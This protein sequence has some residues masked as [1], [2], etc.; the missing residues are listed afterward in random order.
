MLTKEMVKKG[1]N[2]ISVDENS[3]AFSAGIRSGDMLVSING[4]TISDPIDYRFYEAEEF[5][6]VQIMRD[7]ILKEIEI[8]KSEDEDIGLEFDSM[9]IKRCP[10][11]CVFCFV[12]Q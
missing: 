2:I 4:N 9:R 10:N 11:K 5:L 8:E 3:I 1:I 7:G 6:K 12:D